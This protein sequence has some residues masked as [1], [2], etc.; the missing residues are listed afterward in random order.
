MKEWNDTVTWDYLYKDFPETQGQIGRTMD[1][2]RLIILAFCF[3]VFM[4]I[5]MRTRKVMGNQNGSMDKGT[6]HKPENLG[7]IQG[8]YYC[9]RGEPTTYKLSSD[10]H[11]CTVTAVHMHT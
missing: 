10:L 7:L 11:T 5:F 1:L 3:R 6:C 4:D 9:G 8:D 2:S